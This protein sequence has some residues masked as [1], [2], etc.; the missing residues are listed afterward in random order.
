MSRR[1]L[2]L[3]SR[4]SF[5]G[6]TPVRGAPPHNSDPIRRSS[7]ASNR[8]LLFKE[9]ARSFSSGSVIS[10]VTCGTMM[11]SPGDTGGRGRV[12][13]LNCRRGIGGR[14]RRSPSRTDSTVIDASRLDCKSAGRE[15]VSAAEVLCA[16]TLDA[17]RLAS[18][19]THTALE[20]RAREPQIPRQT[21]IGRDSRTRGV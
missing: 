19:T 1:R 21:A 2:I 14:A 15:L 6:I 13:T 16:F 11:V 12:P 18:A 10:P 9:S 5:R 8:R 3:A 20:I 17:Q 7:I 4:K